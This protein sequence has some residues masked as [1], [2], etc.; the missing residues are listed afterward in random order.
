MNEWAKAQVLL[1]GMPSSSTASDRMVSL[2]LVLVALSSVAFAVLSYQT[3]LSIASDMD[4]CIIIFANSRQA[5]DNLDNLHN[6][7]LHVMSIH[8]DDTS[9]AIMR[10]LIT[11]GQ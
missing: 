11:S 4:T 3:D 6:I 7:R 2:R 5:T 10:S 8:R 9:Q 1:L